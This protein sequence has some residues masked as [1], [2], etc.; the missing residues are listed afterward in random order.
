MD[1]CV[2][3]LCSLDHRA[4]GSAPSLE[5]G[6]RLL[7]PNLLKTKAD[8]DAE[9]PRLKCMMGVVEA[10][11]ALKNGVPMGG[12]HGIGHQLGP[13]GV[14]HGETSCVMLPAVLK[15]NYAHGNEDV[16]RLQE[17]VLAILWGEETIVE[18]LGRRGLK[19]DTADAGDVIGAILNEL[20]MPRTLKEVGVGREKLDA[21]AE[22]CL[23]DHWLPTNPVPL[24]T[25]E[26]VLDIL[27]MVV[28]DAKSEL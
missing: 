23:K 10:V 28:G 12:S 22:N 21:L 9:E 16:K 5:K 13:L 19:K 1:H 7:V 26:Q 4:P 18:I 2:E 8:W 15:Y 11:Q 20:G 17:K 6:L 24:T 14:G 3:G 25:K 27:N